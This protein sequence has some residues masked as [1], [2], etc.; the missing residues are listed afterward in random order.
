VELLIEKETI[1]GDAFKAVVERHG[2]ASQPALG[3]PNI[4]AA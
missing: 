4:Q 2:G 3:E 1:D